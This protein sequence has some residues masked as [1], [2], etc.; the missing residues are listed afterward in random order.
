M[1]VEAEIKT[2]INRTKPIQREDEKGYVAQNASS[3]DWGIFFFFARLFGLF[4]YIAGYVV[5][6]LWIYF[7]SIILAE[8]QWD[9]N[10]NGRPHL[11]TVN[12]S[13]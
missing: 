1:N 13:Y 10:M 4:A 12:H 3:S 5:D 8:Y 9:N 11:I 6:F 7:Y 2:K